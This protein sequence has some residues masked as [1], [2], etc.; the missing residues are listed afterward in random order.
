MSQA[1]KEQVYKEK[2]ISQT[3]APLRSAALKRD[4]SKCQRCGMKEHL[5]IHHM[6]PIAS[7]GADV[8]ENIIV[9]CDS[10]H[11]LVEGTSCVT[12]Q[13]I[14]NYVEG[15]HENITENAVNIKDWRK[16]VYGGRSVNH[17]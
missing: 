4:H 1:W 11:D 8:L 3:R 12:R 13:A 9:L 5:S 7:D 14:I 10:C 16:I 2:V 15:D 6:I 17:Y